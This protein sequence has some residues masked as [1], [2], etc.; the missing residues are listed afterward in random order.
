M[1][2]V[3]FFSLGMFLL[4]TAKSQ[5]LTPSVLATAGGLSRTEQVALEWTLGEMAVETVTTARALYTQGFH[6][7]LLVTKN[8]APLRG[9]AVAGSF[10][11]TLAPN[12]V[13]TFFTVSIRLPKPDNLRLSLL[14]A[15]GKLLLVRKLSGKE[16]TVRI[17]TGLLVTGMYLLDIRNAQGFTLQTFKISKVN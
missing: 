6:Q 13:H 4:F 5:R 16:M 15:S 1:K 2:R 17:E 9:P 8:V 11:V 10:Q 12:P 14:D 7:P 3:F